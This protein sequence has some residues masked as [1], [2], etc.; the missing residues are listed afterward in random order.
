M[1]YKHDGDLWSNRRPIQFT[2]HVGSLY[3]GMAI[4]LYPLLKRHNESLALGYVGFRLV[5]AACIVIG[6][7]LLLMLL[8][9]SQE[10]V[11][12]AAK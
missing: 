8:T 6:A 1:S 7:I 10:F 5:G 9:L 11:K 12:E 4:T 3:V 2:N